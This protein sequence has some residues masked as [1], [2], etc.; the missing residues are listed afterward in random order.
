MSINTTGRDFK[1]FY[2]DDAVW[3]P[4]GSKEGA[5]FDDVAIYVDGNDWEDTGKDY[6][7]I[8]DDAKVSFSGG[9]WYPDQTTAAQYEGRNFETVFKKWRKAQTHTTIIVEVALEN[10][11]AMKAAVTAAGGKVLQL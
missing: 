6:T 8:P 10:I 11:D 1:R 5:Y 9:S 3:K 2:N 4:P 7:D